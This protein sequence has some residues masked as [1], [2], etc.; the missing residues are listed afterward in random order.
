MK[1]QVL[2]TFCLLLCFGVVADCFGQTVIAW[3][4]E[5]AV[6]G[7]HPST[8]T[9]A[10]LEPG[11]LS[12]GADM[13]YSNSSTYTY[14]GVFPASSNSRT[15][16]IAS[17]AYYEMT[18]KVKEGVSLSLSSLVVR[19]RRANA[20]TANK[21]CWRYSLD[22]STFKDVG[23]SEITLADDFPSTNNGFVQD[24]ID[25][26]GV[27][28]LQNVSSASQ[29]T[30]RLYAWGGTSEA[31]GANLGFG[32]S[33]FSSAANNPIIFN[34]VATMP[35]AQTPILAWQPPSATEDVVLSATDA[36]ANIDQAQLS[37]GTG[38]TFSSSSTYT[39]TSIF[40]QHASKAEAVS[41]GAY[42]QVVMRSKE[43]YYINLNG[44]TSRV[45]RSSAGAV[46]TYR[47]AYSLNGT[48]F[49]DVG[50]GDVTL[51]M[52]GGD[53]TNGEDQYFIDLSG[54]EGLHNVPST[55]QITFRFYAWGATANNTNT[56]FGKSHVNAT[57]TDY[58]SLTFY[59]SVVNPLPVK[60]TSFKG[61]AV[62]NTIKLNWATT[63][64]QN[65]ARFEVLRSSTGKPTTVI[66]TVAG[67]GTSNIIHNY[68][69]TDNKPLSGTNY[70]QLQQVDNDGKSELSEIIAVATD[71]NSAKI[72]VTATQTEVIAQLYSNVKISGKLYISDLSGKTLVNTPVVLNENTNNVLAVPFTAAKGIYLLQLVKADGTRVSAKFYK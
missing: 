20:A 5:A 44:L 68:N 33:F 14:T 45:R 19:L 50:P 10:L 52:T 24:P 31:V 23:P 61:K 56:G 70:Y 62:G 36:D 16:A 1:T 29:I 27:G 25:L 3:K 6:T 57:N 59:G 54:I 11:V 66:G 35:I 46:N 67:N 49:T 4:T 28:D 41:A 60:L 37:R 53:D 39:Y 71:L 63:S 26:S 15:T 43:G 21:Y 40:P 22:G 7:D 58:N 13:I 65:N 8:T 64:E 72:T 38:L 47:W 69:F 18:F 12:R 9:H 48:D 32:K 2:F 30:F 17:N 55:T 51:S 42:Y 34:G